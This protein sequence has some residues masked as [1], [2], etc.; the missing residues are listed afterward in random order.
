[1]I[2]YKCILDQFTVC[3]L[4]LAREMAHFLHRFEI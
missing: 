2:T 3:L 1:M 4:I